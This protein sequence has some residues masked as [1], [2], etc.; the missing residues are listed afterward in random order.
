[1]YIPIDRKSQTPL[2]RQIAL[3]LERM[4]KQGALRPRSP[5]PSTRELAS[6]IGVHRNT[7]LRAYEELSAVGMLDTMQ[8]SGT[9]VSPSYEDAEDRAAVSK[10]DG[11]PSNRRMNW[12]IVIRQECKN[13]L[14]DKWFSQSRPAPS[15]E[16]IAFD[17]YTPDPAFYPY[18]SI[19]KITAAVMRKSDSGLFTYGSAA[20]YDALRAYVKQLAWQQ[21]IDMAKNRVVIVNGSTQGMDLISRLVLNSG[22]GVAF[23]I[24]SYTGVIR[25]FSIHGARIVSIPIHDDGIDIDVL[26]Q[27]INLHAVKMIYIIP[28]FH[29]PTGITTPLDRRRRIMD[30]AQRT[31]VV[32]LEDDYNYQLRFS[33]SPLLPLKALDDFNQVIYSGSFSKILFP[34]FRIGWLIVPE[35][36]FPHVL[37]VKASLD[38]STSSLLQAVVY[39]YCRLGLLDK[40]LKKIRKINKARLA[41][42]LEAMQKYFPEDVSWRAPEGGMMVWIDL[43]PYYDPLHIQKSTAQQGVMISASHFF[44]PRGEKIN[45]FRL[46]YAAQSS[47][48]IQRG[49]RIIGKILRASAQHTGS[50]DRHE[51]EHD[52]RTVV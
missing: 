48:K 32:I 17:R 4:L 21:G 47:E 16:I 33:G 44:V 35:E 18:E 28:N 5:L 52:G 27:A 22:D 7:V 30:I 46:S 3:Q 29:N 6:L 26:E 34:G 14:E 42:T 40:H 39:E 45:G 10:P 38:I 8:G 19:R 11:T 15:K 37:R 49:I 1:M 41:V 25:L 24:P 12:D 50:H 20:G 13:E 2:H 43:P 9:F 23:G 31:K 51:M 36:I